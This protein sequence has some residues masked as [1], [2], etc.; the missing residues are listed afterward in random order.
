MIDLYRPYIPD[1]PLLND[2]LHSK[3]IAAGEHTKKFEKSI[4]DYLSNDYRLVV[5][6]YESGLR[7]ALASLGIKA[8]DEVI[9]PPLACLTSTQPLFTSGLNIVWGDIDPH[10]GTL[11]PDDVKNRITARTK[12]IVDYHFC[13]YPGFVEEI[14]ELARTRGIFVIDDAIEAFGTEYGGLRIGS[15]SADATV[16]SFNPVRILTTID[17]G[18]VTFKAREHYEKAVIIRDCGID[19]SEYRDEL[20]EINPD[21]DITLPGFSATMSNVNA[22]IGVEQFRE[23]DTRLKKQKRIAGVWNRILDGTSEYTP[24]R[25]NDGVPNYWV[26]GIRAREKVGCIKK[27]RELGF[28]ASGVHYNNNIYS[29]FNRTEALPGARE[30]VESFVALPCGW[31]VNEEDIYRIKENI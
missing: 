12:A 24:I 17:G 15:H 20:G 7:V 11:D 3:Q 22:Y 21:C 19:R 4:G 8:G 25:I 2:V 29:I 5:N 30:F 13:G 26:F 14:N 18:C 6:S 9:A 16:F 23:L 31:W 10:T 1:L 28:Y 27:F